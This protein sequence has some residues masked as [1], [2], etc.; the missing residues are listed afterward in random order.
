MGSLRVGPGVSKEP[1]KPGRDASQS[2]SGGLP[3]GV[4][5]SGLGFRV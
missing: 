1:T 2:L 3:G 5:D 4:G